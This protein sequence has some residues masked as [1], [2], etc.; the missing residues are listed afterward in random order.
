MVVGTVALGHAA[1]PVS[2]PPAE[3]SCFS[4]SLERCGAR[5]R[6]LLEAKVSRPGGAADRLEKK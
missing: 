2:G 5:S 3:L 1:D 4:G 6:Q